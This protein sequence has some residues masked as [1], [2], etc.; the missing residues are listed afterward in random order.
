M[1]ARRA[2]RGPAAKGSGGSDR[3]A[4]GRLRARDEA[5]YTVAGALQRSAGKRAKSLSRVIHS[6]PHSMARAA[7]QASVTRGPRV[8]VSMQSR[9]KISQCRSPGSTI[10]Q[11]GC[12]QRSSQ[13]PK[14]S[15]I[16]AGIANMRGLV[17]IRT[18]ALSTRGDS[19][20]CASPSMV[21]RSHDRHTWCCGESCRNADIRTFTSG[22]ITG[23]GPCAPHTPDPQLPGPSM[24][25]Q[26]P[27]RGQDR[28]L[29]C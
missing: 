25:C 8:F 12:C 20:N 22:R 18:T 17:V 29:P 28:R 14:T 7:N 21:S 4:S 9:L 11:C 15:P 3:T 2:P 19:P 24:N 23:A 6:Q 10:R 5:L 13:K 27:L 26:D 1:P 16:A